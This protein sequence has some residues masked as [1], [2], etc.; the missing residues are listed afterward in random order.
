VEFPAAITVTGAGGETGDAAAG[1]CDLNRGPCSAALP[2]GAG[3]LTLEI[4]P[5]PVR[6]MRELEFVVRLACAAPP[7]D[8][9]PA[10]VALTMPGM[11]MGEN[12]VAL[13]PAAVAGTFR[14]RGTIVRCPSGRS[15]WRATVKAP[16]LGE[17]VFDFETDRS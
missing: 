2:G 11:Y 12:T 1:A 8:A 4:V 7:C 14:G 6:T 16:P 17:V 9:R 5:R 10:A 15:L 13:T 3:T